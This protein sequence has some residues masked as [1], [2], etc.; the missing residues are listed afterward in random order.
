MFQRKTYFVVGLAALPVC[1]F[2]ATSLISY[3]V[4]RDS[5]AKR[6][7]Q[8]TLPLTSDNVY[9]EI[10]RDLLRSALISSL[11]AHDTFVRDWVLS[12]E[13]APEKI[14]HYLSEIRR[15]YDTITA[16]FVS[17]RTRRYCHP[18]GIFKK[19]SPDDPGDAWKPW[20]PRIGSP[21]RRTVTYSR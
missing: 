11:M 18:S 10:Q 13:K 14:V 1:G 19:V 3:F 8:A 2:L 5:I 16:F 20:Q 7:S 6:I 9:S 17:D 15:K 12:G 21:A 4:A